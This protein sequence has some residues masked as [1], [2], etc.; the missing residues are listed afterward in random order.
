MAINEIKFSCVNTECIVNKFTQSYKMF[1]RSGKEKR[2]ISHF[3]R[4]AISSK[5]LM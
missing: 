2:F 4:N 1:L 3:Y 5:F